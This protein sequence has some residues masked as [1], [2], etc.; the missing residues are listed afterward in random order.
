[1]ENRIEIPKWVNDL[2]FNKKYRIWKHIAFWVFVYADELLSLTGLT[3]P[4]EI[5]FWIVILEI[6]GD[7]SMVYINIYYLLPRLFLKGKVVSYVFIT[8]LTILLIVILNFFLYSDNLEEIYLITYVVTALVDSA[9]ILF[10]AV[11]MKLIQESYTSNNRIREL[12]EDKLQTELAYL[13]TQVNPHFLFN[14]LN[15]VYVM[16]KK[17]DE[18]LPETIMQLSDLLR[19]QLYDCDADTVLLRN[20][21][22]YLENYL[23]LEGLR[24]QH[25]NVD[26][27]IH[28]ETNTVPIRPLIL[29]PFIENAFKYSNS[30]TGSDYIR[31]EIRLEGTLL[32]VEIENNK[33]TLHQRDVGGIGLANASRRLELA[34]PKKHK[35]ELIEDDKRYLVKIEIDTK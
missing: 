32:K 31:L 12:K 10:M 6:L 4:L 16:A 28:G 34:Y 30:G 5:P 14:T 29:L 2:F 3:E 33:G 9:A 24:R 25:L 22:T 35:L 1:M 26:F 8:F 23:K 20:E 13:R 17:N 19:Y 11:A 27:Q 7:M 21:I 15:N 18:H